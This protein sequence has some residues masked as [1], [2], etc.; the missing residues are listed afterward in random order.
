MR[1]KRRDREWRRFLVGLFGSH[2]VRED[3]FR[4]FFIYFGSLRMVVWLV[5]VVDG[6]DWWLVVGGGSGRDEGGC[7]IMAQKE[8]THR[9]DKKRQV[10]TA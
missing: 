9:T 1:P 4:F 6:G 2:S 5:S 8:T 10:C 3:V 7:R